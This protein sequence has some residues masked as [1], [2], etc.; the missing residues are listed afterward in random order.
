MEEQK[1]AFDL[2]RGTTKQEITSLT[3]QLG[4]VKDLL[5]AREAA[6]TDLQLKAIDDREAHYREKMRLQV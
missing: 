2:E 4:R 5:T 6:I 3:G 1:A